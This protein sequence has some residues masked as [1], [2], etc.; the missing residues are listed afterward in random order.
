[1][2]D[3]MSAKDANTAEAGFRR[4]NYSLFRRDGCNVTAKKQ[5]AVTAKN[6]EQ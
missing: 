6:S 3:A 2:G 4:G 1:M 5:R